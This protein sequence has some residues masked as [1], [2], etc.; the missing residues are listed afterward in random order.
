LAAEECS[1]AKYSQR[2]SG[3]LIPI[4]LRVLIFSRP[5]I[6]DLESRVFRLRSSV[7]EFE[8]GFRS[9]TQEVPSYARRSRSSGG[10]PATSTNSRAE[11]FAAPTPGAQP[12]MASGLPIWY[13]AGKEAAMIELTD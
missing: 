10:T 8:E 6:G 13:D 4:A 7:E 11:P 2:A 9:K 3:P 5:G 12:T 1:L